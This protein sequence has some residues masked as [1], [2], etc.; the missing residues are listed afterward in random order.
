MDKELVKQI[1]LSA[2][3]NEDGYISLKSLEGKYDRKEVTQQLDLMKKEGLIETPGTLSG[4]VYYKVSKLTQKGSD[5][6]D[7]IRNA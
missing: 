4:N 6:L 7:E 5:W 1:L 2:E 3:G